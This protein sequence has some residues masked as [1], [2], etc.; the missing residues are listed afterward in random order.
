MNRYDA[1]M[2]GKI[3]VWWDPDECLYRAEVLLHKKASVQSVKHAKVPCLH[4][5]YER[6]FLRL[7]TDLQTQIVQGNNFGNLRALYGATHAEEIME[8]TVKVLINLHYA[9]KSLGEV[10]P[11]CGEPLRLPSLPIY[12]ASYAQGWMVL[13]E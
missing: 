6:S 7:L 13:R 12:W 10:C 5:R 1:R 11:H 3:I 8:N 2:S 4:A 9:L